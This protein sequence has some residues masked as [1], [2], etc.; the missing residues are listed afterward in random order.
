[1][2]PIPVLFAEELM[3]PGFAGSDPESFDARGARCGS[4]GRRRRQLESRK[5]LSVARVDTAVMPDD[6]GGIGSE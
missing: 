2:S 1:M 5:N 4:L 6:I 3:Q